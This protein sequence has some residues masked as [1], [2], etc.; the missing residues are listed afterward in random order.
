MFVDSY[1]GTSFYTTYF[2]RL[3]N[4]PVIPILSV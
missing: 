2:I 4:D 1:N 3:Y